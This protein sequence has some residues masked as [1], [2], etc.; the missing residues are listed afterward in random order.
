MTSNDFTLKR[1][2]R[3][4]AAL[5][6]ILAFVTIL[7]TA[8]SVRT[9]EVAPAMAMLG[10]WLLFL[11][12]IFIGTRYRISWCN[13]SIVQK[14]SGIPDV[15]IKADQ[16]T[17]VVQETSDLSTLVS[18]RRPF[19]RIAIYSE[20]SDGTKFIDVSPKHFQSDDIRK[21]ML[22]I[23]KQRPDLTLPKNLI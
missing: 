10:G 7:A 20:G 22:A 23:H 5:T 12:I 4:Y 2:F 21:L 11:P 3:P 17:R 9:R 15:S 19:R 16:I 18:M 8:A 6:V 1:S 14:A 13:G